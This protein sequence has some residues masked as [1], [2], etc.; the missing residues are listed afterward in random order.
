MN[1]KAF[2]AFHIHQNFHVSSTQICEQ[3]N[4]NYHEAFAREKAK[5]NP[6]KGKAG[7]RAWIYVVDDT[8][9]VRNGQLKETFFKTMGSQ[10]S[11]PQE[12]KT[13]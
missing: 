5:M 9:L 13:N 3:K 12:R 8:F 1:T 4:D 10:M 2:G 11:S 7:E 6:E